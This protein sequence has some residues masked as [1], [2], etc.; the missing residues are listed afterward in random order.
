MTLGPIPYETI[1]S[2]FYVWVVTSVPIS[3]LV[4]CTYLVLIFSLPTKCYPFNPM[5]ME[6]FP[7][8]T[9]GRFYTTGNIEA[10]Y[11]LPVN[12]IV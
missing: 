8:P 7:F 5:T 12:V 9:T 6:L 1:R 11:V 2:G 10:S 4:G 3:D